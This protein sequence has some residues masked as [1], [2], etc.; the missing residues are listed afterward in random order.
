MGYNNL[1]N[2][3]LT[4]ILLGVDIQS[5]S[6]YKDRVIRKRAEMIKVMKTALTNFTVFMMNA[7]LVVGFV[8]YLV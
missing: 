3:Y 4:F 1:W 7:T 5:E 2:Y 8:L 6:L